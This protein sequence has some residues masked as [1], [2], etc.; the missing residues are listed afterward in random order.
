MEGR[1]TERSPHRLLKCRALVRQAGDEPGRDYRD[2][3]R[4][5]VDVEA[6]GAVLEVGSHPIYRS[7]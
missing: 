4:R 3:V 2:V 1:R 7:T 5:E 6:R